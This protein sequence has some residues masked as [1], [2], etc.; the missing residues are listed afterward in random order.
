[1]LPASAK[2]TDSFCP[3][4]V[5][6]TNGKTNPDAARRLF[7]ARKAPFLAQRRA[8]GAFVAASKKRY[9]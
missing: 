5:S 4:A 3:C 1:M 8:L 9:G 7:T 6:A 2:R